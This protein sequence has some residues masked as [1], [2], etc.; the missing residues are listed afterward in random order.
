MESQYN[1][2]QVRLDNV[3][4]R[5]ALT[6][7][8][9]VLVAQ[10]GFD[11]GAFRQPREQAARWAEIAPDPRGWKRAIRLDVDLPNA[12]E[13]VAASGLPTPS[14]CVVNPSTGHAHVAYELIVW[15]R[16]DNLKAM[17]LFRRVREAYRRTLNGDPYYAGTFTHN[18]LFAGWETWGDGRRYNLRKLARVVSPALFDEAR[19]TPRPS[20][21]YAQNGRNCALFEAVRFEAYRVVEPY[22]AIQ[23][24]AGFIARVRA[25]AAETNAGFVQPLAESEVRW[26]VASIVSF[27][28]SRYRR[29]EGARRYAQTRRAYLSATDARRRRA[30]ELR[31]DGLNTRA[32]A[33]EI[34][35]TCRTIQRWNASRA[36]ARTCANP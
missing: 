24:R 28:W 1:T 21:G 9:C 3:T 12:I 35:V 4:E 2:A 32:I 34:Q 5:W 18:P 7:S 29:S 8:K 10:H 20:G 31:V 11:G 27:S 19:S 16:E 6:L 17:V 26:T 14:W 15:V 33:Q 23:D 13:V 36:C 22:R 30:A 25:F